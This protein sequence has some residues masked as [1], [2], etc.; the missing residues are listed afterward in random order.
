MHP[1]VRLT[2]E[3]RIAVGPRAWIGP[4]SFLH[5]LDPDG[6]GVALE[7]GEGCSLAGD[8]TLAAA[9]RVELGHHVLIARGVYVSDHSHAFG[10]TTRPI[11]HQGVDRVAPVVIGDGAWLGTNVVVCP[12]VRI[13]RNA[14][15]G[16]N[17]V[18]TSDV[19]D[20][21]VV[22]GAPA[23]VLRFLAPQQRRQAA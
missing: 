5:V 19:P 23:R 20:A 22:A 2:G 7:I 13:G 8:V 16:A 10:D 14:V 1:S 18:V 15:V 21:A 4:G 9:A 17:A 11:M 12:G 3:G 6:A